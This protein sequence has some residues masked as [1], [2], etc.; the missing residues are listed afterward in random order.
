MNA[1]ATVSVLPTDDAKVLR[2][3]VYEAIEA[4]YDEKRKCYGRGLKG[5]HTDE[6]LAAN[7]GC[8]ANLIT[9]VREEFFGPGEPEE[10]T[11]DIKAM[12][13]TFGH[14][15]K[16][17]DEMRNVVDGMKEQI[18]KFHNKLAGVKSELKAMCEA[19][20]WYH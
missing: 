18:A 2:R 14:L 7:L 12:Q 8:S 20:G 4:V 6:S 9:K 5:Y 17:A 19:N 3:K 1:T 16:E 10:P 11:E 13:V 15:Q